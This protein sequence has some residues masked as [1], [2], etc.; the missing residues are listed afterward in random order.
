MFLIVGIQPNIDP[1]KTLYFVRNSDPEEAR[2]SIDYNDEENTETS[3]TGQKL[4]DILFS[5]FEYGDL[6]INS[7][8]YLQFIVA[9]IKYYSKIW[10]FQNLLAPI[11]YFRNPDLFSDDN[12]EENLLANSCFDF[13][14]DSD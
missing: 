11:V 7:E 5:N 14:S 13:S 10:N 4:F 2:D 3:L 12:D 9:Y 1:L 8:V 6:L